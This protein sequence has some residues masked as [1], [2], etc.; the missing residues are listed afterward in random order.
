MELAASARQAAPT[1][2]DCPAHPSRSRLQ[3]VP[4]WPIAAP[5]L[6]AVEQPGAPSYT[7][8]AAC[9]PIN[10][11]VVLGIA[12]AAVISRSTWLMI[13]GLAVDLITATAMSRL[14]VIRRHFDGELDSLRSAQLARARDAALIHMFEQ[15][16]LELEKLERLAEALRTRGDGHYPVSEIDR[17]LAVY[18]RLAVSYRASSEALSRTRKD[19][20]E[21]EIGRLEE[22]SRGAGADRL[23]LLRQRRMAI[24]RERLRTL[25]AHRESIEERD[26]LL[27]LIA[28]LIRLVYERTMSGTDLGDVS[29]EVDRAFEL[30]D[31]RERAWGEIDAVIQ[32]EPQQLMP[33]ATGQ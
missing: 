14:A 26:H 15:H 20:I 32:G 2:R 25:E 9:H 3:P 23:E 17:L 12:V 22:E 6:E 19:L 11:L 33:A 16:R 21:N 29:E 27:S 5:E 24:A 4:R 13:I 7:L 30:L 1:V 31:D 8:A 28:N 10:L 18:A